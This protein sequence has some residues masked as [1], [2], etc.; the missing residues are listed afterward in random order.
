MA[1]QLRVTLILLA[2]LAPWT[3]TA[4]PAAEDGVSPKVQPGDDF[5]GYANGAWLE[6]TQLPAGQQRW[7]TRN[8]IDATA[9]RQVA[10]VIQDAAAHPERATAIKAAHF[11]SAYRDEDAI[12][13]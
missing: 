5:F 1:A 6:A 3:V 10:A 11:Y 13:A 4:A 2:A 12:E 8:D 7:G 9:K